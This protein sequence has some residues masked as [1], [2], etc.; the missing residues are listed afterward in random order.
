MVERSGDVVDITRPEVTD[1]VFVEKGDLIAA[2][3]VA[4]NL[5]E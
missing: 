4:S 3:R 2:D 1:D 5:H